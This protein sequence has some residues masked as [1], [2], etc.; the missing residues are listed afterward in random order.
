MTEGHEE[1]PEAIAG[2]VPPPSKSVV[3]PPQSADPTPGAS[4][5]PDVAEP[6]A[7]PAPPPR[8]PAPGAWWTL[9]RG[10]DLSLSATRELRKASVYIGILTLG[11]VGPFVIIVLAFAAAQGGFDWVEDAILGIPPDLVPVDDSVGTYLLLSGLIALGGLFVIGVESQIMAAAILGGK[12]LGRPMTM[13]EALKRSRQVFWRVVRA[14]ILVGLI[15]VIPNL[16]LTLVLQEVFG[17]FSEAPTVILTGIGALLTA[18]FAYIVTGVVLGDVGA[19]E[20]VR[21]SMV[22][23]SARWRLAIAVT[24]VTAIVGYIELFAT[25][26]GVDVLVRVGSA[27]HLGF[28]SAGA[29]IALVLVVLAGVLAIGSLTFTLAALRGAPQVVAFV[30]MTGYGAGLDRSREPRPAAFAAADAVAAEVPGGSMPDPPTAPEIQPVP[31]QPNPWD[32]PPPAPGHRRERWIS[33]PMAIAIA[34]A[35]IC[36]VGGVLA[37]T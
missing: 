3:A 37:L 33:V 2:G 29:T 5:A 32:R 23:A 17:P 20:S 11:L 8:A 21:R 13:R 28:D 14:S 35:A 24:A 36:G 26:A 10:L 22:L 12:A 9:G 7:A 6:P 18:P 30:G 27:L 15:L 25:G 34:I 1:P 31:V 16:M 19:R 4:A